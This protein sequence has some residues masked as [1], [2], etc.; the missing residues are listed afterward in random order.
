MPKILGPDVG[1][2][3]HVTVKDGKIT[4]PD[5]KKMAEHEL[6]RRIP[7]AHNIAFPCGGPDVRSS[8]CR[9]SNSVY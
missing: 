2:N 3:L 7:D 8:S 4:V 5:A 6:I 9:Q 1:I